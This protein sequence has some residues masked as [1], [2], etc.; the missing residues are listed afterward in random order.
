MVNFLLF[1][2]YIRLIQRTGRPCPYERADRQGDPVPTNERTDR[3][4][5][6]LRKIGGVMKIY[7]QLGL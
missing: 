1:V 7:G 6:S 2:M 5:P 4:T 3:K